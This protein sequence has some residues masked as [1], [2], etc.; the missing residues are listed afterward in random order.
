MTLVYPG[1]FDPVTNGHIDIARRAAKFAN[2]LIIAVLDNPHKET[3][4]SVD[5]RISFLKES[6]GDFEIESFSGLLAEYAVQKKANAILRGLRT[7][8]DFNHEN[9][10]AFYNEK[11]SNIETIFISASPALSYISSTITKEAAVHIYKN[12]LDDSFIKELVPP[13]AYNAL[14]NKF[15]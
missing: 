9:K 12:A 13:A 7:P 10:Y 4:F 11:L 3:L 8:E 15:N 6:L 14:R 1:S 2:R 5:E